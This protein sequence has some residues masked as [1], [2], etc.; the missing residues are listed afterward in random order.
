MASPSGEPQHSNMRLGLIGCGSL[1]TAI[2]HGIDL[3]LAGQKISPVSLTSCTVSVRSVDSATLLRNTF[4]E[5]RIPLLIHAGENIRTVQDSDVI[6]LAVPPDD[7]CS[8][9]SVSSMQNALQG[10]LLISLAAGVTR[11]QINGALYGGSSVPDRTEDRCHVMRAMPNL[12]AS[13]GQS[14][15][16]LDVTHSPPPPHYIRLAEALFEKIGTVIHVPEQSFNACTFLCGSTPAVIALFCDAMIDGAVA[17]GIPRKTAQPIVVQVLS[18]AAALMQN[19]QRP[20]DLREHVCAQPG[21]TIGAMMTLE[22]GG[23]R[24]VIAS[25]VQDGVRL[26]SGLGQTKR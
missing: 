22:K 23:A 25:A 14:M 3:N 19:G 20:S 6:L 1:G 8:V 10:K 9:L 21:C 12:A 17:A 13:V 18:S 24:G 11:S 16:A 26:A 7:V 4:S 5:S 15:T 2:L